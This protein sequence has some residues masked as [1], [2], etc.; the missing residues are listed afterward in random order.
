MKRAAACAAMLSALSAAP[1][2]R[3]QDASRPRDDRAEA[4]QFF[5][6]GRQAYEV[7]QYAT[8]LKAYEEAYDRLPLPEI[9]FSMAQAYRMRF[10]ADGDSRWARLAISD[11][12]KYLRQS[13]TGRR[14]RHAVMHIASLEQLLA[15]EPEQEGRDGAE[16]RAPEPTTMLMVASHTARARASIDGAAFRRVPFAIEV[17]PGPHRVTVRAAGYRT[18]SAD[19]LAVKGRM[20]IAPVELEPKP[21][22]LVVTAAEGARVA[23]DGRTVGQAPVGALDLAA[24]PH[25]VAV[26]ER[27]HAT[28]RTAVDLRRGD[29]VHVVA[30]APITGQ[31]V[32]SYYMLG[33]AGAAAL[34]GSA[35]TVV[36]LSAERDAKRDNPRSAG[37][38]SED[39]DRY[40][41][42]VSRRDAYRTASIG[43]LGGA[44]ALSVTA[45]LLYYFDM[46]APERRGGTVAPMLGMQALG[47]TWATSY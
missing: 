37:G 5:E 34:A 13:P 21:A 26:L 43:L 40:H 12:R 29:R 28:F 35:T 38:T 46:P 32:L 22:R 2:L 1:G 15:P 9:A 16:S 18:A 23:V 3:A 27:G 25:S 8:A 47:A 30:D 41:A 42:D 17:A 10:Y 31:R 14:R 36:A 4:K 45:T 44:A 6:A 11:Y 24:G 39:L 20:A 7:G 33:V 19:W